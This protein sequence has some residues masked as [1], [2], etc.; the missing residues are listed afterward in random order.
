MRDKMVQKN[1][2]L[3]FVHTSYIFNGDFLMTVLTVRHMGQFLTKPYVAKKLVASRY[4][5]ISKSANICELGGN[6]TLESRLMLAQ[7]TLAPI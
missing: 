2:D 1:N 4:P 5:P 3:I 7:E 6:R